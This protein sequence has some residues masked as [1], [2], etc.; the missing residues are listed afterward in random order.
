M[1]EKTIWITKPVSELLFDGYTSPLLSVVNKIPGLSS[2]QIPADR[3]GFFYSRNGSAMFDG[4]FNMETGAEDISNLG[5][6]R[7]W[8]YNN[9]TKYYGGECGEVRGFTGELF[10]PGQTR[11]K[12]LETFAPDLCR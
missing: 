10:P 5:K 2:F 8:N 9:R 12:T 3:L 6:L 4:V 1:F 11:N 7:Y